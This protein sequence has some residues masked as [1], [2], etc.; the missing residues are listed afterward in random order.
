M[1]QRYLNYEHAPVTS[2][3]KQSLQIDAYNDVHFSS[4]LPAQSKISSTQTYQPFIDTIALKQHEPL[5]SLLDPNENDTESNDTKVPTEQE[6]FANESLPSSA[7]A[8]YNELQTSQDKLFFVQYIP[9]GTVRARWYLVQIDYDL[10]TIDPVCSESK[11]IYQ[12]SFL[13]RHSKDQNKSDEKSRW[14]P[15]WY[16]YKICQKTKNVIYG[17]R[18]QIRP[19]VIPDSSKYILWAAA[20]NLTDP[21]TYI[22]GPFNFNPITPTQRTHNTVSPEDWKVLYSFCH[23]NLLLPPTLG[24]ESFSKPNLKRNKRKPPTRAS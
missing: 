23:R 21:S 8:L 12:C 7:Q 22:H 19:S 6:T 18:V 9:A 3:L 16:N 4:K 24:S 17:K 2:P 11:G 1:D 20:L 13:A 10:S 5:Q 15:D 14:W